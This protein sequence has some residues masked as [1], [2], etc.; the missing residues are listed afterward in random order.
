[1][2]A[3]FEFSAVRSHLAHVLDHARQHHGERLAF[4]QEGRAFTYE[5]LSEGT[6]KIARNL[7]SLGLDIGDRIAIFAPNG[8]LWMW[9]TF[10]AARAG[11]ILVPFNTRLLAKENAVVLEAA[12]ARYMIVDDEHVSDGIALKGHVSHLFLL[13]LRPDLD[14]DDAAGQRL[15]LV[16]SPAPLTPSINGAD[17]AHLYFTSGTTGKPKGVMLTHANVLL[18][19]ERAATALRMT[20]GDTWAHI[21]PMFHLADAWATI[22]GTLVGLRH[23]F[24]SKFTASSALDLLAEQSVSLTNLVPTMLNLMVAE[25]GAAT[26]D[27]ARMRLIMSGGAPIAPSLVARIVATFGC[28][29]VQT[30][31]MTETSPYLTLSLLPEHMRSWLPEQQMAFRCKTGRPFPGIELRVVDERGF[32]VPADGVAVGE[33]EVRGETVTPGYWQNPEA[34]RAAFTPDGFLRTGDLAVMD[35][36]GFINIVDRKKDVIITGG[37]NV[38]STEVEA[39]LAAH[40]SVLEVAVYGVADPLWGERVVA[41]VVLRRGCDVTVD[42]LL[43]HC[44]ARLAGYKCPRAFQFLETLPKTGSGKIAKRVL[45]GA[46]ALPRER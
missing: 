20:S 7:R 9:A 27:Y 43:H 38:Y 36:E 3:R 40:P 29:Y 33:I 35:A 24:L 28:E 21:A 37:E 14:F 41:A 1:M 4:E 18:H 2:S 42:A 31:G 5:Q 16:A 19:A 45:R 39:A 34:T 23:V 30:Y 13:R 46:A 15:P 10:A 11:L 17:V 8:P 32:P 22:A 25:E 6:D 44:R 12:G 26:R